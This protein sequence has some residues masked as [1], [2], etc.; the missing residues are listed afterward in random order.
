MHE[1]QKVACD[2]TSAFIAHFKLIESMYSRF[3]KYTKSIIFVAHINIAHIIVIADCAFERR[4]MIA[5]K[6]D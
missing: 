4:R 1:K 2:F 3:H 6:I 5:Q